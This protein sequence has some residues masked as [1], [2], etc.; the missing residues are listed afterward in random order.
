MI[1]ASIQGLLQALLPV[2]AQL[3]PAHTKIV[4]T[5]EFWT[6]CVGRAC[7]LLASFWLLT[8]WGG[9]AVRSNNF[10]T[11]S[12]QKGQSG[13]GV[14]WS[15]CCVCLREI[16]EA[17]T[18]FNIQRSL[19][20]SVNQ[21]IFLKLLHCNYNGLCGIISIDKVLPL[22]SLLANK[23][24]NVYYIFFNCFFLRQQFLSINLE[25]LLMTLFW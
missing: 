10:L 17:D 16:S 12:G 19:Q 11:E 14:V 18:H 24:E 2:T 3:L 4:C 1:M 9:T 7:L 23:S 21:Y 20:S 13:D 22:A 6:F 15:D 5:L 8:Q 25:T